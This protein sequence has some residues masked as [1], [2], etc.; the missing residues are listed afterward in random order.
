M[1]GKCMHSIVFDTQEVFTRYRQPL[2]LLLFILAGVFQ[3]ECHYDHFS[4]RLSSSVFRVN[5]SK[6]D[7][8]LVTPSVDL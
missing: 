5:S 7:N 8:S 6:T 4:E 3:K 1:D 2:Y